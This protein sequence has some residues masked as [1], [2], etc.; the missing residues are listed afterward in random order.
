MPN[1]AWIQ[2]ENTKIGFSISFKSFPN[3]AEK[4]LTFPLSK[5]YMHLFLRVFG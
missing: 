4:K 2:N 1:S 5:I 3:F